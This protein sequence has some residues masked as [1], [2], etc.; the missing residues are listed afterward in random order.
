[1]QS[2]K[3]AVIIGAGKIARGFIAHLL[4]HS[5]FRLTFVD[6]SAQLAFLLKEREC[7][8]I[9][10]M[11]S[12]SKDTVIDGFDVLHFADTT[13]IARRIAQADAVFVSIGGPNLPEIAPILV[14]AVR[15][16]IQADRKDGLNILLCEN[17]FQPARWLRSLITKSLTEIE[18]G[19]FSR[20]VGIVET[21]VMRSV[22]EPTT[23]MRIKDPLSLKAQDM[24][25]LPADGA[26]F[27][28]P[29]P[30]VFGLV[31]TDNF[32]G[33]L[34]RKLF[35][36]NALNAMIA[37]LGFLKGYKLLSEAANDPELLKTAL[38]ANEESGEALCQKY[39][40]LP[41]EQRQFGEAAIAKYQK[42]EIVDPIERNARDPLRKL[43]RNDRLVGPACLAIECGISPRAL[44]IG[45]GAA[46][47]YYNEADPTAVRLQSMLRDQG[48]VDVI[49]TVCG[50][51][52]NSELT[53]LVLEAYDMWGAM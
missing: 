10:I 49:R 9:H 6:K 42:Q 13:A 28:G 7:Y 4:T 34:I 31:P 38:I 29:P 53:P 26:A 12:P 8:H 2:D 45:I 51:D 3:T 17:Y 18:V 24:W 37:Y 36:Y 5:G 33:G 44:S 35:T 14:A 11:G 40:F 30:A 43:G 19:W 15:V 25:R 52:A 16:A 32:E 41:E 48:P 1:M 21:M 27:V 20:H 23:E 50:L 47:H 46:L 39:G 22:I